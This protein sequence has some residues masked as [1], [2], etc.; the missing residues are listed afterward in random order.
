MSYIENRFVGTYTEVKRRI[1]HEI[2]VFYDLAKSA[3]SFELF[4]VSLK[5]ELQNKISISNTEKENKHSVQSAILQML[6]I[7]NNEGREFVDPNRNNQKFKSQ[8]FY[9]I[10]QTIIGNNS[11]ANS[12]FFDDILNLISRIFA[13]NNEKVISGKEL[14]DR[15]ISIPKATDANVLKQREKSKLRVMKGLVTIIENSKN[16]HKI[17]HFSEE[18]NLDEKLISVGKWWNDYRFHLRYAIQSLEQLRLTTDNLLPKKVMRNF[19]NGVKKGIPIF[20]NPYFLSLVHIGDN[21]ELSA[22]DRTIRDYIFNSK[23]LV[24]TF[25]N[26]KAWEK[27]DIIVHGEPNAAGWQLPE[28]DSV[29]RRYPEVAIFIPEGRGRA[30]AGLCVSCQ[31]MYGFQKGTLNFDLEKMDKKVDKNEKRQSIFDY[32]E[33]DS[34][35]Q[36]ILITGGDSFMNTDTRLKDILNEFFSVAER[37]KEISES[38]NEGERI[39]MFQRVRLGTRMLAYLPQR[40]SDELVI[41]LRDFK[42]RAEKIGIK[43]FIIQSH[44]ETTMEITPEVIEAIK[45]LRETGWIIVNQQVF[46]AAA[47]RRSHSMQLR[48][49]LNKLGVLP[50]YTFAVKGF[51]E[52]R[53]NFTP[54]ARVAQEVYEEKSFGKPVNDRSIEFYNNPKNNHKLFKQ[55]EKEEEIPFVATDRSLINLPALGKS[56]SFEQVGITID[57]RRVLS[58]EHDK[59]RNHS[60]VVH[61]SE[62]VIIVEA[63]SIACYLRQLETMGEDINDYNGIYSYSNAETERRSKV[64]EYPEFDY[65]QTDNYNNC[66]I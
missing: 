43:Q 10:Y 9:W 66:D 51:R 38:Q 56:L 27:E 62:K 33:N 2:P 53:E 60:P 42:E 25:G 19:E 34:H 39:A 63:K 32:F 36:D 58:F 6:T 20:I 30:C 46:T 4:L 22:S 15:M 54:L 5:E 65:K 29:H 28:G 35:L 61:H 1:L 48:R 13:P 12:D 14:L 21:G 3:E 8:P 31:R 52:N 55:I 41:I 11:Y 47:S 44:F 17:Y 37:K 23:D 45:M 59:F 49:E 57:G 7:L 50:Y 26:I 16:K 64:F 24:D 40:V 18:K